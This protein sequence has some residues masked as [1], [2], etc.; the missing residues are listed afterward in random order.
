MQ[1]RATVFCAAP[2]QILP[3]RVNAVA[4][5]YVG[6]LVHGYFNASIAAP[7]LVGLEYDAADAAWRDAS[8]GVVV[9]VGTLVRFRISTVHNAD[10]V[11]SFEGR[12]VDAVGAVGS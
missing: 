6:L 3:G 11:L 5:S 10:G 2:P 12:F 7:E 9:R 4:P 8:G 1:L